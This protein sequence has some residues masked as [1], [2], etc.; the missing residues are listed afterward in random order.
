MENGPGNPP[1]ACPDV[2]VPLQPQELVVRGANQNRWHSLSRIQPRSYKRIETGFFFLTL[3]SSSLSKS[4]LIGSQYNRRWDDSKILSQA[5][6]RMDLLLAEM[7]RLSIEEVWRNYQ[8]FRK[9]YIPFY[10]SIRP[11]VKFQYN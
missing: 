10:I 1:L 6:R 9:I 3:L 2:S 5:T 11:W 7:L 8:D 4:I